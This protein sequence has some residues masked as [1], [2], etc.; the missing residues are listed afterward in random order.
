MPPFLWANPPLYCTYEN[1]VFE[2]DFRASMFV[3]FGPP[4]LIFL[5]W[6]GFI[7]SIF[8]LAFAFKRK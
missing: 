7:Y 8:L 4:P 1:K 6:T 2:F 3:G 5:K